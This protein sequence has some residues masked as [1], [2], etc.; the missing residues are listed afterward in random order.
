MTNKFKRLVILSDFH[1]GHRAGL[2]PPKYQSAIP[3][4]KYLRV[5]DECWKTFAWWMDRLKKEHPPDILIVNGD[6]IDGKGFRSGSNELIT[7]DR[8]KQAAMAAEVIDYCSAKKVLL[9]R[10]TPYHT[11]VNE[12]FENCVVDKLNLTGKCIEDHAWLDINGVIFS[13]R[14]F[15]SSSSIPHGRFTALA[16]D[17]LWNTIWH[18]EHELQP[19]ARYIIRSH[20]HYCIFCGEGVAW[21]AITTPALQAPATKFGATR[22]SN[23]I[24]F[25]FIYFDIYP[26]GEVTEHICIRQVDSTKIIP[27]LL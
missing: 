23:L 20:V 14:H 27:T 18:N 5:Q 6:A 19:N 24:H 25:G 11:G 22:C 13:I 26:N 4:E 10:G 1:C 7:S 21:K 17:K 2:T 15:V 12:D 9:T 3:G 16:R 8:I